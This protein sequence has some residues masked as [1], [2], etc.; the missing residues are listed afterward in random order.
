MMLVAFYNKKAIGVRYLE[1]ALRAADFSVR[2]VFFKDFNSM[3]PKKA[4][5]IELDLLREEIEKN[6]TNSS[7]PFCDEFY[8]SCSS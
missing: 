7:L 3:N 5:N 8:V 1:T 6:T 2:T 4:T